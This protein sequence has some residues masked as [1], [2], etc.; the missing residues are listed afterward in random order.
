MEM[1]VKWDMIIHILT[2]IGVS[3]DS[4]SQ[5][6]TKGD[7]MRIQNMLSCIASFLNGISNLWPSHTESCDCHIKFHLRRMTDNNCTHVF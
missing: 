4:V 6:M 7:S 2:A 5:S 3:Q 1:S